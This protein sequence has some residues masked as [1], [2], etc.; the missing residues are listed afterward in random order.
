MRT[1][2]GEDDP[3]DLES[4]SKTLLSRAASA[5]VAATDA[6]KEAADEIEQQRR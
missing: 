6:I 1:G 5:A 3:D 4:A 2:T